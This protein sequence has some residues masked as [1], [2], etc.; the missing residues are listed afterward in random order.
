MRGD[1]PYLLKCRAVLEQATPHARGS[2]LTPEAKAETVIGY[3]ACAG[4]DPAIIASPR[5]TWRLP[6]MRGDRPTGLSSRRSSSPATPHARGSTPD[7]VALR[8]AVRG[9][10]AC[11]GIDPIRRISSR[12]CLWLPRMRGDRPPAPAGLVISQMAT[13][14]A[15]GSTLSCCPPDVQSQGYPACAG[16]DPQM[17]GFSDYLERLPRM[18]GDRPHYAPS[19]LAPAPATPHARGSTSHMAYPALAEPGYPA[20]AGIDPVQR[21]LQSRSTR[22]PR[23]RGDRPSLSLILG[24]IPPATPHARGSTLRQIAS[25][26]SQVGYPACAG[27]DPQWPPRALL[28]T[29]LP[30]MRGDR[31]APTLLLATR[32]RA[33]PHARGSTRR[34]RNPGRQHQ[35]YP[36]CAGIDPL[37]PGPTGVQIRL[38][39]MRGDRPQDETRWVP[40]QQ[41]T[42][43]ARGSTS[44][45][46]GIVLCHRGYPAC[47]G[48][49]HEPHVS[50]IEGGRLPRMRGDRPFCAAASSVARRATPHARGS[51]LSIPF[52]QSR[53]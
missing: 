18:R 40:I 52:P 10:P 31:P 3:P 36:A 25:L 44:Y 11:A 13:P 53:P 28:A 34:V 7:V 45:H 12:F 1:R 23:M 39:R 24:D 22:L 16:I 50:A 27:I 26:Q 30:R 51:T 21:T 41:A 4:I 8:R 42:P 33:T 5:I 46:S 6:R 35:G 32:N 38:P 49:D 37:R 14:H 48:I 17:A 9:Y 47:A 19:S 2:T 20:C 29:R 15:R 43:H